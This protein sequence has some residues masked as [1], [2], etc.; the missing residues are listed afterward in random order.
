[1]TTEQLRELRDLAARANRS[2]SLLCSADYIAAVSPERIVALVDE[3]IE[4][5][6]GRV[7]DDR[8]PLCYPCFADLNES[9]GKPRCA[10]RDDSYNACCNQCGMEL[11]V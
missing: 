1:M 9:E 7:R 4:L 6:E 8:D 11:G 2:P 5:R 10:D 3:V